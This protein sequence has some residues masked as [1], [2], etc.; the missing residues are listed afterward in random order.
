MVY[1]CFS[2]FLPVY[3][4]AIVLQEVSA[5]LQQIHCICLP[6][7]QP[8]CD[9]THTCTAVQGR[10]KEAMPKVPKPR[11]TSLESRGSRKKR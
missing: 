4:M 10:R 11:A 3:A 9:A 6:Q 8:F 7:Q 5:G 1:P 2:Q